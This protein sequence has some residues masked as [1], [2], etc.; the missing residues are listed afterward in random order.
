MFATQKTDWTPQN[1]SSSSLLNVWFFLLVSLTHPAAIAIHSQNAELHLAPSVSADAAQKII[2]YLQIPPARGYASEWVRIRSA[3]MNWRRAALGQPSVLQLCLDKTSS[4]MRIPDSHHVIAGAGNAWQHS[5][6]HPQQLQ[7]PQS[8][9]SHSDRHQPSGPAS[10][11][12]ILVVKGSHAHLD[13]VT[14]PF[15]S[16]SEASQALTL[17]RHPQLKLHSIGQLQDCHHEAP[18]IFRALARVASAFPTDPLSW[19]QPKVACEC[20]NATENDTS[21][22]CFMG[23]SDYEYRMV[24]QLTDVEDPAICIGA[25]LVGQ[26]AEYFFAGLPATDL[27]QSNVTLATLKDRVDA[28][29]ALDSRPAEFCLISYRPDQTDSSETGVAFRICS[30]TCLASL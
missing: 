25:Y 1:F 18:T 14:R 7:G 27:R 24:L 22:S 23:S 30:T 28:L 21:S 12:S 20:I 16:V 9:P 8:Q 3:H 15:A 26:E 13:H 5:Q 29:C 4:L 10:D 2:E 11:R 6:L 17:V 19:T